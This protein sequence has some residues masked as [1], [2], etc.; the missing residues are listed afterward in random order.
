L[1]ILASRV[2]FM[3]EPLWHTE[4]VVPLVYKLMC[5]II[6]IKLLEDGLAFQ[7]YTLDFLRL[8]MPQL[9]EFE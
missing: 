1:S 3:H 7:T 5:T 6:F 8:R 4:C 9:K 2:R